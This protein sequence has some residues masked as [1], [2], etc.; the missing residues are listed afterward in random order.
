M[1]FYAKRLVRM[2]INNVSTETSK[3]WPITFTFMSICVTAFFVY[4]FY[5]SEQSSYSIIS[6]FKWYGVTFNAFQETSLDSPITPWFIMVILPLSVYWGTIAS[7]ISRNDSIK[8]FE[9]SLNLKSVDFLQGRVNFNFTQPKYNFVCGYNNIN[10]LEMILNTVLVQ[11]KYG[12]RPAVSEIEL[13]FTV[14]NNKHFSLKNVSINLMK[15]IYRIIDCGKAVQNF[16]YKFEGAGEVEHIQERIEDY[17]KAGCKQI[18]STTTENYFK[19]IS[20]IFFLVGILFLYALKNELNGYT[21]SIEYAIIP[22][23]GPLA[24]SFL[25]DF[26]LLLDKWNE[27]KSNFNHKKRKKSYNTSDFWELIPPMGLFIVKVIILL[28][29][30]LVYCPSLIFPQAAN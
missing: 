29:M 24:I 6:F 27:N 19:C 10:K 14:F 20:I 13:K 12:F 8:T 23:F 22:T 18:L 9:K 25:H 7:Y 1:L 15:T 4:F 16:S 21:D 26:V 28:T 3:I 30:I 17:M 5:Q 2:H 11:G